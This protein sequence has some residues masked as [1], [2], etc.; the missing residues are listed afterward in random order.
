MRSQAVHAA[1]EYVEVSYNT[2]SLASPEITGF[3]AIRI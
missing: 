2:P 1:G 3:D